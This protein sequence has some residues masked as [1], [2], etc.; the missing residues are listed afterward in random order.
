MRSNAWQLNLVGGL[1]L[2]TAIFSNAWGR[3]LPDGTAATSPVT[4]TFL[5]EIPATTPADAAIWISGNTA[6][7]GEWNGA[8]VRLERRGKHFMARLGIPR[9]SALEFKITR[10]SW[11][12]VEKDPTGREL[13]NRT[14]LAAGNDTVRVKV[15]AWR[16]QTEARA[17][18][19]PST[20]VGDVRRHP[21]FPAIRVKPRDVL[22]YLPP[23]YSSDSTRRY[24][25]IYFH[26]GNNVFD[27]ATSFAGVEWGVDETAERLI[28]EGR[29]PP[30]IAVA[31]YNTNDRMAEY[32]P[33]ADP[34][35]GG[36][37][38]D[39]YLAFIL[40]E[41]QPF[42]D[43]T[44]RTRTEPAQTGMVGS[45]LGAL[46]ALYA[47]LERPDRVGLV[48][49]VSP[50]AGWGNQDA[51]RRVARG[52]GTGLRIW[53]DMGE[54]EATAEGGVA[55]WLDHARALRGALVARGYREGADFHY[56]E[57]PGATH[58]ETAWAARVD[59]LLEFLLGSAARA[60]GDPLV[61]PGGPD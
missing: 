10:G 21:A 49:V 25:V 3:P 9:E 15:A 14:H 30:F 46:I 50:A 36:G 34:K 58:H 48:G 12:T 47:G 31:I 20:L 11:N 4:L 22:V 5:V 29:V 37:R 45:S 54:K 35:H 56:E 55:S 43:R 61:N 18:A 7:L 26:D 41:L 44:Y 40:G 24:P 17:V 19:R 60:A 39:D 57:V 13:P 42:I 28:G 2:S 53:V 52:R 51:V 38:A 8:G 16:D 6:E 59:R 32:S 1:A 33:V 27:S 23:G